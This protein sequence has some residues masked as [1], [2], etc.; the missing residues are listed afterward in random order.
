M[1]GVLVLQVI[2]RFSSSIVDAVALISFFSFLM[3]CFIVFSLP[4]SRMS[5]FSGCGRVLP[6]N[7][8]SDNTDARIAPIA[9]KSI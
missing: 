7:V 8:L 2:F 5:L 4:L 9:S 1:K 6:F 3:A